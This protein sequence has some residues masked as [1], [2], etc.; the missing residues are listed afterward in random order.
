MLMEGRALRRLT[1]E[2]FEQADRQVTAWIRTLRQERKEPAPCSQCFDSGYVSHTR[3]SGASE[4]CRCDCRLGA[5]MPE[6]I[7]YGKGVRLRVMT[8]SEAKR[9]TE[10]FA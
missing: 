6:W 7:D 9:T 5:G 4:L 1:D 10:R 8:I 3:A 2:D